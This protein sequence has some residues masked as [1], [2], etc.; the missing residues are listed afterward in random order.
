MGAGFDFIVKQAARKLSADLA[1]D[2][3][4]KLV[5]GEGDVGVDGEHLPQGVL[6][7]SRL[8]VSIQEVPH[9]LQEHRVVI[10]HVD[11]HCWRRERQRK[12]NCQ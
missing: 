8:H 9:H 7:L 5:H 2:V 3:L 10:L 1:D 11:V 12:K 6:V 4:D